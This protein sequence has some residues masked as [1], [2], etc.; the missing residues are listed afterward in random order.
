MIPFRKGEETKA[1][2]EAVSKAIQ[3]LHADG[4]LSNLSIKY[5]GRDLTK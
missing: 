4:T 2:R 1:L 3:E 5:F